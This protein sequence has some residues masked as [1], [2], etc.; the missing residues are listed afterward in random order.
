MDLES[1][2]LMTN[3][4]LLVAKDTDELSVLAKNQIKLN[5]NLNLLRGDR[6]RMALSGGS[7]PSKTYELLGQEDLP[8]HQVDLFLGDE[9]W[10]NL[11]DDLSNAKMIRR[12]LLSSDKVIN[13]SFFPILTTEY[14]T[15]QLSAEAYEKVLRDRHKLDEPLFDLVVLGLGDD[16]H[17]ASLFPDGDCLD[18]VD[19]LVAI[20]HGKGLDRVTLTATALSNTRKVIFL[21]SGSSKQ[22]ALQRLMDPSE[23]TSRTPARLI[24]PSSDVLILADQLASSSIE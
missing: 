10:V 23:S 22:V 16:G 20:S 15:P 4:Q 5:L 7:T 19:K 21:V 2:E 11:D 13:S 14:S 24:Q 17:T 9:R 1:T 8:W 18:I 3:Y 12:K 6:V